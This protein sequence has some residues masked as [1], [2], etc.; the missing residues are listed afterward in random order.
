LLNTPISIVAGNDRLT[1]LSIIGV[2]DQCQQRIPTATAYPRKFDGQALSIWQKYVDTPEF[3]A[4][5]RS[6]AD[7]DQVWHE[8]I[9]CFLKRC[10]D[11]GVVPFANN[12]DTTRNEFVENAFSRSRIMLVRWFDEIKLFERVRV[13]KAFREYV[14]NDKGIVIRSWSELFNVKDL[15]EF[16]AWL[17]KT[18]SP[19][20]LK[21]PDNRWTKMVQPHIMVWVRIINSSRV[22]VGY[23]IK[24]AGTIN[25]PGKKTPTKKE[26]NKFLDNTLWFPIV[27]AHRIDAIKNRLF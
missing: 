9:K 11:E 13:R 17:Q 1:D 18:P 27:R 10:E 7:L 20:F 22:V 21:Y 23:E 24:L 4:W 3:K 12:T 16:E 8:T 19:R 6:Q 15:P 5:A 14:A 26:V 2:P 25:I